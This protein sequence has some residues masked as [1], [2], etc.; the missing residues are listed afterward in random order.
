[1][2]VQLEVLKVRGG[3]E[4]VISVDTVRHWGSHRLLV[5]ALMGVR[6]KVRE[7]F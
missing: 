6:G 7:V 5:V 3:V 2:G 4:E 1:M